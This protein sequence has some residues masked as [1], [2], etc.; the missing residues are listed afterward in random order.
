MRHELELFK[1]DILEQIK[2]HDGDRQFNDLLTTLLSDLSDLSDTRTDA[3]Q[4]VYRMFERLN[5]NEDGTPLENPFDSRW[6]SPDFQRYMPIS[7]A[8][9]DLTILIRI[10]RQ[11]VFVYTATGNNLDDLGRDY[12]F[13]RFGE[14]QAIRQGFTLDNMGQMADFPLGSRFITRDTT[15][16]IVFFIN[17]TKDGHVLFQCESYGDIGNTYF[18]D[19]S[20]ASPIGGIGRAVITDTIAYKPG[21]NR[22]TDEAYRRRFLRFLRRRAFGGN[23]AQYIAETQAIDG[24][25]EVAV[26][27]VWRGEGTVKIFIADTSNLPVS[28]SF[29]AHVQES[30]D[31]ANQSGAG[32]SGKAN[33]M[34]NGNTGIGIAPIGHRV[35]VDTP[36]ELPI[37]LFFRIVLTSDLQLGQIETRLQEI[38]EEYFRETRQSVF[39]EWERTYYVNE[40][41]SNTYVDILE[42][43]EQL[44]A[45]HNDSRIMDLSR[46]FPAEAVIQ[47]HTFWTLVSGTTIGARFQDA[48]LL[49]DL[50]FENILVNNERGR[51]RIEQNQ[52]MLYLPVLG[53]LHFEVVP[54]IYLQ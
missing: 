35:T 24:V 18:G 9:N 26:F 15:E 16:P 2:I 53:D 14:T 47:T 37:D 46:Y 20:P 52:E 28:A 49:V 51:I 40:G 22:E 10:M 34:A 36:T 48:R 11:Q 42:K 41:I 33:G 31:P 23:V 1:N 21:Q 44:A 8:I 12:D 43:F 30:L 38:V 17:Q 5:T 13:H 45:E 32:A 19:L 29:A 39:D 7:I 6:T 4:I 54:Y 3:R 27:P 25:G 50:D